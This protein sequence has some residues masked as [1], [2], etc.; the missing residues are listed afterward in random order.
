MFRSF[1]IKL[2]ITYTITTL[3]VLIMIYYGF[4]HFLKVE[5]EE[6]NKNHL[7][8]INEMI[9]KDLDS[10]ESF[11]FDV[12]KNRIDL[13]V[14]YM[15]KEESLI[16][17]NESSQVVYAHP[18]SYSTIIDR[19]LTATDIDDAS[20]GDPII[21]YGTLNNT[22]SSEVQYVI[23][24]VERSSE[25]MGYII[26]AKEPNSLNVQINEITFVVFILT[27]ILLAVTFAIV[28]SFSNKATH[29]IAV[30]N[31][32]AK[33]IASGQLT[34][35]V[36][37]SYDESDVG[38]LARNFNYMAE[39]LERVDSMRKQFI[40][41]VSHDLRSPLTSIGGFAQAMLDGTI[42]QENQK[43]YLKIVL[44]ETEHLTNLTQNILLLTQMENNVLKLEMNPFDIN[45]LVKKVLI[46]FEQE[47]VKKSLNVK[48]YVSDGEEM[49]LG[50]LNQIQ[51]VIY[52][53]V[54]NAIKFS[55]NNGDLIVETK[56]RQRKIY[57][58]ISDTGPGMSK[59]EIKYMWIRFH[60]ADKSRGK[61]KG[62]F[63][64]GLSI[65]K[66]I[67]SAHNQEVDVYSQQGKGTT[68]VFSLDQVI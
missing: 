57:V 45:N 23:N 12:I 9:L 32:T 56:L 53:I 46:Q 41:N 5:I 39:E 10:L 55:P 66:E 61:E 33:K 67:I 51:R 3:V 15:P 7:K 34:S 20:G 22:Y 14:S 50:D 31:T 6:E 68:F 26:T 16:I 25:L 27:A 49:V 38:D 2:F 8:A 30:F 37:L 60:K 36:T 1:S 62:G 18:K 58:S 54:H 48:L 13:K 4:N 64:I 43:K 19:T 28:Y 29:T 52:N 21:N 24:P 44:T 65:V 42:P 63:G 11:H 47:I 59:E 35:R 40:A 17:L